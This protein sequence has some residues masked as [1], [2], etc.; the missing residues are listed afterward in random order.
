MKLPVTR[1][2][3]ETEHAVTVCFKNNSFFNKI[4]YKPG[5]FLTL[6]IPINNK[7]ENRAYSFSSNPFSE[8]ELKITVKKV[9]GGLV[10]NYINKNLKV[11]DKIEIEKPMGSFFI[12][13]DKKQ[14]KQYV[15][16]AGGSGITPVYSILKSV[17][18]KEPQSK[19]LL[20]YA[21]QDVENIIFYKELNALCEE[22]SNRL[23]VEHILSQN[24][25]P[26]FHSGFLT[27]ELLEKI[28]EKH[29][30]EFIEHKYM[31]CGPSGYMEKVKEV[32]KLHGIQRNQIKLEAFKAPKIKIDRKNLV[33]EV[34]ILQNGI[35]QTFSV[36]GNQTILHKAMAENVPIPYSCRSG[37]C[38][39]CKAKCKSGEVEMLDG[40]LLSEEEVEDG[41]ILTC[42]TYPA[43]EK[44]TIEIPN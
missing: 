2:I 5:Q 32:L 4:K 25:H 11:G 38:S 9:E 29:E 17:L 15:L 30:L 36:P 35:E 7:I 19:V 44:L 33:S 42:I 12:E 6:K 10:S 37:M 3:Q 18:I 14:E 27:K 43:S 40:H 26:N 1:I 13:P 34:T 28:F 39:T 22:Y 24:T 41:S 20:I 16:F 21:N 31:V 23:V 8:K